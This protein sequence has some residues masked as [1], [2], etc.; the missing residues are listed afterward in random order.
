MPQ[1][2]FTY[3]HIPAMGRRSV[4]LQPRVEPHHFRTLVLERMTLPLRDRG[5]MRV[6]G[7]FGQ[8]GASLCCVSQVRKTAHQ[9]LGTRKD[10]G[11]D[12]SGGG[13]HCAMQCQA[14]GHEHRSVCTGREG[15]RSSRI[16][17]PTAPR[18]ERSLRSTSLS[19]AP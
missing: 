19:C 1:I 7:R 10:T 5:Q 15:N 13:S 12:L 8:L 11:Q 16:G 3:V 9:S 14:E 18:T 2:K 4:G 6:R 17:A